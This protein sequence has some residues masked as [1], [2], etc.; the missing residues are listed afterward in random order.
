MVKTF[1]QNFNLLLYILMGVVLIVSA[2][3]YLAFK[4]QAGI[5]YTILI[6]IGGVLLSFNRFFFEKDDTYGDLHKDMKPPITTIIGVSA[7]MLVIG[8]LA[9]YLFAIVG[10]LFGG[11]NLTQVFTIPLTSISETTTFLSFQSASIANN[12]GYNL[13]NIVT[14]AGVTETIIFNFIAVLLGLI[15]TKGIMML[16]KM[17]TKGSKL[18]LIGGI[19]FALGT[20]VFMHT[21]N[22]AYTA[23]A[24]IFA[25]VFILLSNISIY[26]LGVPLMFWVGFHMANNFIYLIQTKGLAWVITA[27]G[28]SFL[29]IVGLIFALII[30]PISL[31][32][33]RKEIGEYFR[34]R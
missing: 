31:I 32:R 28:T 20:F 19:L 24:F 2:Y 12:A 15:F 16:M 10:S 23:G 7:L 5:T 8:W 22:N 34:N 4:E 27:L 9:R 25:G 29:G 1:N 14:N 18:P 17:K 11:L 3:Q 30:I 6:L 33:S 26:F 13:F 21:L